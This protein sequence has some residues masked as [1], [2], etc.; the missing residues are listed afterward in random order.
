M[1]NTK[2]DVAMSFNEKAD[3]NDILF[4]TILVIARSLN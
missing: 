2:D 3:K 4:Q 1:E